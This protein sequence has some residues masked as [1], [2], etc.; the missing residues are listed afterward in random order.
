MGIRDG[1]QILEK[2]RM[3]TETVMPNEET[4]HSGEDRRWK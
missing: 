2:R 3:T 1:E 4:D